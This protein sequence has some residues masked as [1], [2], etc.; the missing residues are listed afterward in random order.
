MLHIPPV[1]LTPQDLS[2]R[3]IESTSIVILV[4]INRITG[5]H[6]CTFSVGGKDDT[7][8]CEGEEGKK[9][10]NMDVLDVGHIGII[11]VKCKCGDK[12]KI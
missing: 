7:S 3:N 10:S 1:R 5:H 2:S 9:N 11:I 8:P 4:F 12:Y 6:I